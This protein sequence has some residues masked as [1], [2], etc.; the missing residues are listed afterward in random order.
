[1][2]VAAILEQLPPESLSA[3]VTGGTG[4]RMGKPHPEPY[5]HRGGPALGVHPFGGLASP[6]RNS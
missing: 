2:I 6:S 4:I 3:V 1:M 5:P